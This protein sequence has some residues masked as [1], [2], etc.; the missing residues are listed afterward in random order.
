MQTAK[1]MLLKDLDE[2]Y[3][4]II[5]ANTREGRIMTRR[6]VC[7]LIARSPA[8]RLY[9]T[10]EYA[11]RIFRG[12]PRCGTHTNSYRVAAMQQELRSRILS[13]PENMRTLANIAKVIAEPAPSFY[14]SSRRIYDFL[15]KVYDRRKQAPSCAH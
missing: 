12:H 5:V 13:L 2:V 1:K 3:K 10:P 6:Q 4:S 14:L 15:Y 7:E 11:L 9:I 8:P